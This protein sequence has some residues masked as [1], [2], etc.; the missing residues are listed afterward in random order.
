VDIGV[1]R[2]DVGQD[3]RKERWTVD[4]EFPIG[5]DGRRKVNGERPPLWSPLEY[6]LD[7]PPGSGRGNGRSAV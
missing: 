3:A 1:R 7:E 5:D 6:C 2:L 4:Q